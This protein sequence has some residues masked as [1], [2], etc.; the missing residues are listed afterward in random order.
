M[1]T[2]RT[3][4]KMMF[5][6]PAAML[7]S[8]VACDSG[9]PI[10]DETTT[11]DVQLEGEAMD[12]DNQVRLHIPDGWEVQTGDF[13]GLGV[14]VATIVP[15]GT[16]R[17]ALMPGNERVDFAYLA[18]MNIGGTGDVA[19]HSAAQMGRDSEN[20]EYYSNIRGLDPVDID[21]RTF[22][23]YE[24]TLTS[25]GRVGPIQY[26]YGEADGDTYKFEIHGE[27]DGEIPQEL[28][29]AMKTA[30]FIH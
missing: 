15:D 22:Y 3:S 2:R 27:T 23:G 24:G 8:L 29:T 9:E 7:L 11:V 30:E 20:T 18:L 28:I 25:N 17:D 14:Y 26:W 10:D 19:D 13:P 12:I 4:L 1:R 5:I 6:I 21:K 16:Q